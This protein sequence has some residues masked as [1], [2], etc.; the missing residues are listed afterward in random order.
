MLLVSILAILITGCASTQPVPVY[1]DLTRVA[2]AV[3]TPELKTPALPQPRTATPPM[4]VKQPGLPATKTTDRTRE[5]LQKAKELIAEN[6]GKSISALSA[7]LKRV[8]LAQA[9]DNIIKRNR[10][11]QPESDSIL[12]A[13]YIQ[14]RQLFE[15]YGAERGPLLAKVNILVRNSSLKQQPIPENADLLT[16]RHLTEANKVRTEIHELDVTYDAKADAILEAAQ[17][18]INAE[19]AK[20]NELAVAERKAATTKAVREAESKA[21]QTQTSL[22]VQVEHLVPESL[23]ATP[24]R[25][26]SVPGTNAMPAPPSDSSKPI[27]GSLVERRHVLDQEI[28]IWVRS[29]GRRRSTSPKGVRDVTEEFLQWRSAHKVGP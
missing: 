24:S 25:Q 12:A 7:M 23:P 17:T 9:E 8:Y 28:E 15:Q 1:V 2:A 18:Q 16:R 27:F 5:R 22:D 11:S 4:L 13:A 21:T 26:V 10:A 3:K 14:I 6:R 20:L 19:L 29:T